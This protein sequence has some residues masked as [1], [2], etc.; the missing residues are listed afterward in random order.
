MINPRRKNNQILPPQLNPHP[1][2]PLIANIKKPFPV[3]NIPN[4]LILM[5][6]LAE[7]R[8]DLLLVHLPQRLRG[9]GELVPVLVPAFFREDVDVLD[10]RAVAIDYAE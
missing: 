6:M 9:D 3:N 4:L 5:Q 2:I 7:E 10:C 8:L 1:L